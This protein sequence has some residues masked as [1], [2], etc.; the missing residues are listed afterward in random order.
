MFVLHNLSEYLG[1][2]DAAKLAAGFS[3]DHVH[4]PCIG[5]V[6][7]DGTIDVVMKGYD[8]KDLN[9][10]P[11]KPAPFLFLENTTGK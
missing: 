3:S 1:P 8:G 2:E 5:D 11:T 7:G 4:E 9:G 10:N 6:N